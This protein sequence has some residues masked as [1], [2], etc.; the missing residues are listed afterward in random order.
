MEWNAKVA[1]LVKELAPP[2]AK[3]ILLRITGVAEAQKEARAESVRQA[4]APLLAATVSM[5]LKLT[6][7]IMRTGDLSEIAHIMRGKPQRAFEIGSFF[8]SWGNR[9]FLHFSPF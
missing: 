7:G 5:I 1:K 6:T 3:S 2:G 4:S 9:V 8:L